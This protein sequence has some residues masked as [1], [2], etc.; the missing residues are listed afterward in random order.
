MKKLILVL[1][2]LVVASPA[3]AVNVTI[4]VND[5]Y[6]TST[7]GIASIE[8][9]VVDAN[10]SGFG[11]DITVT[12]ANI[13]AVDNYFDK[14]AC[15]ASNKGYG[16]FPAS[17]DSFIDPEDPN[18]ADPNYSPLADPCD[19][20]AQDGLGTNSVTVEFGTLYEV[21][22]A[23][24]KSG[25]LC[26]I[27]VNEMGTFNVTVTENSARG[28]IV[29][30]NGTAGTLVDGAG[31]VTKGLPYPACWDWVSHCKGNATDISG[32]VGFINNDDFYIFRDSYLKNYEDDWNDGAG[33]YTPCADFDS[34][35]NINND[36]FYLF[37]DNYL[38][39][40]SGCTPASWPP[41]LGPY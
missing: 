8:Y 26:T 25:V 9:T 13:V 11:L 2:M 3:M 1:A 30:Q 14:G 39:T 33:P 19:T 29:M 18:Y 4:D 17:F 37:R 5:A 38:T 36:D 7:D 6:G 35:G 20:G 34:N 22:N 24:A 31:T 28:K 10:V 32:G 12:G 41:P 21:G 15:D 27:E 40:G 16:I 23:P